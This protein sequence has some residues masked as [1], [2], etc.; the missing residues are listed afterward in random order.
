MHVSALHL[1]E[2]ETEETEFRATVVV[3]LLGKSIVDR[4]CSFF[5]KL[6]PPIEPSLVVRSG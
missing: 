1:E 6:P 5:L 2:E 4:S 3:S